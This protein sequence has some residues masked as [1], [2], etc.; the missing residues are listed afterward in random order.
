MHD[1]TACAWWMIKDLLDAISCCSICLYDYQL[2]GPTLID[3]GKSSIIFHHT[4]SLSRKPSQSA[5]SLTVRRATNEVEK[6]DRKKSTK[7]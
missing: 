5:S 2:A 3:M 4:S 7:K 1:E 6:I